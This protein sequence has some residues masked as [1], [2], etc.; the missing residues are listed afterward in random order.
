MAYY[1][2][3][4]VTAPAKVVMVGG[5]NSEAVLYT[6]QDL[7]PEQQA[8]ARENIGIYDGYT[9]ETFENGDVIHADE[10]DAGI[11]SVVLHGKTTKKTSKNLCSAGTVSF[12]KYTVVDIEE[13]PPGK[14]IPSA[15][16]TSSD[17]DSEQSAI[18]FMNSDTNTV[19][20]SLVFA[21]GERYASYWFE[22]TQP[23][24]RLRLYASMDATASTNDTC[25]WADI[26]IEDATNLNHFE[27]TEYEPYVADGV[28][29]GISPSV[30]IGEVALTADTA[31]LY[32]GDTLD[33][34]SAK[35][36]RAET[37][38]TEAVNVSGSVAGLCGDLAVD[39][40][41]T[42]T[43]T[44]KKNTENSVENTVLYTQ[45]TLTEEQK[46]QARANI[47]VDKALMLTEGGVVVVSNNFY[48]PAETEFGGYYARENGAWVDRSD[49]CS[50]GFIPCRA[51]EVFVAAQNGG[52][53]YLG[54]NVTCYDKDYNFVVGTHA[55][56]TNPQ[57]VTPFTI[58]SNPAICYFK[59]GFYKYAYDAGYYQIN[60]DSVKPYDKYAEEVTETAYRTEHD[61]IAPNITA[62][63]DE[64]AA[65]KG[66]EG[67]AENVL[68]FE[69]HYNNEVT[70]QHKRSV[71]Y[72]TTYWLFIIND[73]KF[74]GFTIK[75]RLVSTNE[76]NPLGG[77]GVT[78][79]TN[80]ALKGDYL[81][82]VNA[83]LFT[84]GVV[85]KGI[86]I[87]DGTIHQDEDGGSYVLGID[88]S[89]NFKTYYGE[90]A[91]KILS[92]GCIYA[93]TGWTPIIEDGKPV[94]DS[95]LSVYPGGYQKHP[96]QI[97]GRLKDGKYFT[98]ACD[99]R[100]DGEAGMSMAEC[101]ETIMLDLPV[102]F[103][104]NLDGGGSM[105]S[106]VGKKLVN[107]IIDNR[108]V[109]NVIVFE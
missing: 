63:E 26:Q 25:T 17:T 53:Y 80:F 31:D 51:G 74:D 6:P 5:G 19:I 24:N 20:Q 3:Q 82:V 41:N 73:T 66:G 68:Y 22:T 49:F 42:V 69:Q 81:H 12:T 33:F 30:S 56:C 105:Q 76:S 34:V 29:V 39:T 108:S 4:K 7:T 1:N 11:K 84:E 10:T 85:A 71:A 102:E 100:T 65:I 103:A 40:E 43:I 109:P 99:G 86:T 95:V 92:D 106:T 104:F 57:I 55:D 98:F 58:P 78:N 64:I 61:V 13:I 90:T 87:I 52:V 47:G 27:V 67:Q 46:A 107:R 2:G 75:P 50:T 83:G 48:N 21:R 88:A 59:I 37:D 8:Q 45:Q 70:I 36:H 54:G 96:R 79:V 91:E 62:I 9:T 60:K 35:V 23:I 16:V 38:T 72:G 15:V 93:V 14:Y 32:D 77:N 89:G 94:D 28:Y 18:Q 44:Y 101:I 97:I